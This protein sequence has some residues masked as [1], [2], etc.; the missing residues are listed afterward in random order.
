MRETLT[1][2]V[3]EFLKTHGAST[4][5]EIALGVRARRHDVEQVLAGDRFRLVERP[6]GAHHRSVYFNL[7]PSV[8]K[9]LGPKS[10]AQ[11]LLDVLE[12]GRRYRRE[13]IFRITERFFLTNNAAAELRA[14][15]YDVR[16]EQDGDV[17]IYWLAS[18]ASPAEP[19]VP[20]LPVAALPPESESPA[21]GSA[22]EV[23]TSGRLFD[24]RARRGASRSGRAA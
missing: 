14:A 3:V 16:H 5:N 11:A 9:R 18:T 12:D 15:G 13:D 22:D 19:E 7:S 21:S 8:P 2:E 24:A 20:T 4:A 1:S 10:R 17:H 6:D 23:V